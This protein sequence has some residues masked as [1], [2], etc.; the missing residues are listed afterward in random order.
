MALLLGVDHDD[1]LAASGEPFAQAQQER[2]GHRFG[3]GPDG[4]SE[5]RDDAGVDCIGLGES[6]DGAGELAD[7]TWID[8]GDRQAGLRPAPRR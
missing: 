1:E 8:D 3:C 7:L 6:A 4:V 2:V 5:M